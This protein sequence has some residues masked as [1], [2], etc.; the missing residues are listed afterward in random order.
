MLLLKIIKV[1]KVDFQKR[2]WRVL[3]LGEVWIMCRT[4]QSVHK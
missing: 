1:E 2:T 3:Y 4:N